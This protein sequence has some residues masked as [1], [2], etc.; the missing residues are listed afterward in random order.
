MQKTL[1]GNNTLYGTTPIQKKESQSTPFTLNTKTNPKE[2]LQQK[3][4]S[5]QVELIIQLHSNFPA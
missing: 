3:E 1:H 4:M 5:V 2:S